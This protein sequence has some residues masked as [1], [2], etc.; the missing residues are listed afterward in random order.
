MELYRRLAAPGLPPE[1]AKNLWSRWLAPDQTQGCV[2]AVVRRNASIAGFYAVLPARATIRGIPHIAGKGE[3]FCVKQECRRILDGA[4]GFPLPLALVKLAKEKAFALGFDATFGVPTSA[5]ALASTAS[6]GRR[7]GSQVDGVKLVL[8][9]GVLTGMKRQGRVTIRGI[10]EVLQG[11]FNV[12]TGS[13]AVSR[14]WCAYE[15]NAIEAGM[16]PAESQSCLTSGD[17]TWLNFRFPAQDYARVAVSA[18]GSRH[19]VF[20]FTRP[21]PG[22]TVKLKYWTESLADTAALNHAVLFC[23]DRARSARAARVILRVPSEVNGGRSFE[24]FW[25]R[26]GMNWKHL[27]ESAYV[28]LREGLLFPEVWRWTDGHKGFCQEMT[29]FANDGGVWGYAGQEQ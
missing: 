11:V 17:S 8:A 25:N 2:Y 7:I 1:I 19:G 5:A 21:K 13:R 3:F 24:K 16:L 28:T 15:V 10:A 22:S 27:E 9:G 18:P 4:S 20:V 23:L 26:P 6:G 12:G 14:G 29:R